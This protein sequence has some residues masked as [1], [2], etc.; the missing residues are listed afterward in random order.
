MDYAFCHDISPVK[1]TA[2]DENRARARSLGR[3]GNHYTLP[4]RTTMATLNKTRTNQPAPSKSSETR[5]VGTRPRRTKSPQTPT[6]SEPRVSAPELKVTPTT[7]TI[8]ALIDV[9]VGNTLSIRGQGPG[10]TWEKGIPL[11]CAAPSVWLWSTEQAREPIVFKL[12]IND[13]IWALGHDCS[14]S[15]GEWLELTPLF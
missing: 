2:I 15:P 13:E 8:V 10:L 6:L 7:T 12:L 4:E 5:V 11:V 1:L 3:N 14:V 9:G